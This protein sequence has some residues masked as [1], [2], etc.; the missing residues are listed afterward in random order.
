MQG[1]PVEFAHLATRDR[2]SA[3]NKIADGHYQGPMVGTTSASFQL[4]GDAGSYQS[5]DSGV[6]DNSAAHHFDRSLP[7]EFGYLARSEHYAA[8]NDVP[9]Y[10]IAFNSHYAYDPYLAAAPELNDGE[11]LETIEEAGARIAA[12]RLAKKATVVSKNSVA[13]K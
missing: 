8:A 12:E 13:R 9:D 1:L 6:N 4:M 5:V 11:V 10:P 7:T 3:M 2:V